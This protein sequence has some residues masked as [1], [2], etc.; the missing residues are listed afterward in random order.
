[1]KKTLLKT[2]WEK[3]LFKV[4]WFKSKPEKKWKTD[5]Y[6]SFNYF[7]ERVREMPH[8]GINSQI[9]NTS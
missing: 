6:Y 3:M 4:S 1:M 5:K 9:K 2:V 8:I 7:E